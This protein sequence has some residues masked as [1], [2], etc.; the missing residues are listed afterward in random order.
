MILDLLHK[1]H[2]YI[3]NAFCVQGFLLG[4]SYFHNF[5][6]V[7]YEVGKLPFLQVRKV[8]PTIVEQSSDLNQDLI[9]LGHAASCEDEMYLLKY[10]KEISLVSRT[11][12][13]LWMLPGQLTEQRVCACVGGGREGRREGEERRKVAGRAG[14]SDTETGSTGSGSG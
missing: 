3:L 8:K 11:V 1:E 10:L 12:K 7:P 14:Q 5:P 4:I 2:E 13:M 6:Q 9:L